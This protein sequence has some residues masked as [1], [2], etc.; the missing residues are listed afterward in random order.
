MIYT[1]AEAMSSPVVSVDRDTTVAA[2]LTLMRR[3]GISS[4]LVPPQGPADDWG[5]MTKRDV[6]NKVVAQDLDPRAIKVG[7]IMTV[8]LI[9]ARPEWTL[10]ECS[11]KMKAVGVRRLPVVNDQ[12]DVVGIISDTDIFTAVEER[13]W[14]AG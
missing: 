13:G 1:V 2:A 9:T 10:K 6:I 3:K 5:I 11:N 7:D 14:E 8:H 12:G 4:V